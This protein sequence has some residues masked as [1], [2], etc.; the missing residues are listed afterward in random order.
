MDINIAGF[1]FNSSCAFESELK[2]VSSQD[3]HWA[4]VT[5]QMLLLGKTDASK[6]CWQSLKS[7][8]SRD[9]VIA[10]ELRFSSLLKVLAPAV[11]RL[12]KNQFKLFLLFVST[13]KYFVFPNFF[14]RLIAWEKEAKIFSWRRSCGSGDLN[15]C[16][17][18]QKRSSHESLWWK[19]AKKKW[20]A[21]KNF[22]T[23]RFN[24]NLSYPTKSC[25]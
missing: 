23:I 15:A 3:C 5:M 8:T 9:G 11:I 21:K 7:L 19:L 18:K 20:R 17:Q 12:L 14:P 6:K 25:T 24:T 1:C 2:A 4:F 22:L 10:A 13:G 16:Q